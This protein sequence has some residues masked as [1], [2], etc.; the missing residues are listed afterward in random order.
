[1]EAEIV[2]GYKDLVLEALFWAL[3]NM[4]R[5]INYQDGCHEYYDRNK[6]WSLQICK[7]RKE[8]VN[9]FIHDGKVI[10][11]VDVYTLT[12]KVT[13]IAFDLIED[14]IDAVWSGKY[15]TTKDLS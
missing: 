13:E 15:V 9:V 12:Y 2:K 8:E 6:E 5:V 1:M 4:S 14:A 3:K 11:R 7:S 10:V